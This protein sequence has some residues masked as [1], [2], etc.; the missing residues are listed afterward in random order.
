[1]ADPTNANTLYAYDNTSGTCASANQASLPN[2][3]VVSTNGGTNW[4]NITPVISATS[5]ITFFVA[6]LGV[7]VLKHPSGG[8]NPIYIAA[9]GKAQDFTTNAPEI[10]GIYRSLDGG[11]TY[12][13]IPTP[14]GDNHDLWIDP[15]N[16]RRMVHGN[17]GGAFRVAD[18]QNAIRAEGERAAL[19]E[20][21]MTVARHELPLGADR[22]GAVAGIPLPRR[23]PHHAA[24]P[25][26]TGSQNAQIERH[27][28]RV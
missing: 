2:C 23:R 18:Q 10:A 3:V 13:T 25:G 24:I 20:H 12:V 9:R 22:E 26:R 15:S 27:P 1:M 14:H 5:G 21:R 19:A 11:A 28:C 16:N 17:D 4:T 7:A 8:P 6:P